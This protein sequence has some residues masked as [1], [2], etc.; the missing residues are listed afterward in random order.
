PA[1]ALTDAAD[2]G[3]IIRFAL[4]AAPRGTKPIAGAELRVDGRPI[5]LLARDRTGYGNLSH[6]V[7]RARLENDR[8]APGLTLPDVAER[9]EGLHL[10]TGPP[11]G[12]VAARLRGGGIFAARERLARWQEA[13]GDRIAVEV[14]RHHVS[15][16][17]E[18]LVHASVELARRARVPWVV[19]NEPRYLDDRGRWVHDLQTSLRAGVE[20]GR[21]RIEG[22]LL[23]NGEWRLKSPDEMARLWEGWEEGLA[24]SARIASEC[25]FS[26]RWLRPPLP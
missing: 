25:D 22:H 7:T 6:L 11:G 13:F 3:G 21:A 14:Q 8:G 15:G 10:L 20:V 4:S 5:A 19:T 18:A 2:L 16:E 23:P 17:E 24:E 26:L 12:D 9:S 1:M